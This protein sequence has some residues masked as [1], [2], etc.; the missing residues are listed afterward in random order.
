MFRLKAYCPN[1]KMTVFNLKRCIKIGRV[2]THCQVC[3]GM[4]DIN[5]DEDLDEPEELQRKSEWISVEDDETKTRKLY[6]KEQLENFREL[7][8]Q[9]FRKKTRAARRSN[10]MNTVKHFIEEVHSEKESTYQPKYA[11]EVWVEVDI[12]TD[13]YGS[14]KRDIH[15]FPKSCWDM[16]KEQGY[17]MS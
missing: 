3:K 6:T 10:S 2:Q 14:V 7:F 9:A 11:K 17:F 16:H 1:C 12:T 8:D 4:L 13:A 15:V 5:I